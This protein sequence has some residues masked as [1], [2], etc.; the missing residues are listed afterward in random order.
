M[1]EELLSNARRGNLIQ[2]CSLD[3]IFFMGA[4]KTVSHHGIRTTDPPARSPEALPTRLPG[5]S[6]CYAAID[7][8]FNNK[9]YF[10]VR[11][12]RSL[13]NEEWSVKKS[14]EKSNKVLEE[15]GKMG[16]QK[17]CIKRTTRSQ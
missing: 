5:P 6:F 8:I 3:T 11:A 12:M 4:K 17:T 15:K 2:R 10:G 14:L 9:L 13:K 1:S 7:F 16:K